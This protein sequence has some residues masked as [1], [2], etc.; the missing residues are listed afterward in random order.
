MKTLTYLKIIFSLLLISTQTTAAE[1]NFTES[2]SVNEIES[3]DSHAASGT[4]ELIDNYQ[5]ENDL[6]TNTVN[7]MC[8]KLPD[9]AKNPVH[10]LP[11][12]HPA[13]AD[14]ILVDKARRMLHLI[15]QGRVLR[16]YRIA[17]GKTPVGKKS[18]EGDN[19][20]P[21]GVYQID[22]KN[23][24]SDF[25]LSLAVSYPSQDDIN[26]ARK[27]GCDPGGDIM[28]HGLPNSAIKRWFIRHPRDW[29]RGCMAVTSE[30]IEEIYSLI[31]TG[32]RIEICP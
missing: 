20:T 14:S 30:E 3:V 10:S 32:S 22:Y 21:E 27:L 23:S 7:S 28:V 13:K 2:L 16:T 9:F 11:E 6:L 31:G 19:K 4:S 26:R 29:T 18:C 1:E 5:I 17:L 15:F 8:A 25:H 24:A 12:N